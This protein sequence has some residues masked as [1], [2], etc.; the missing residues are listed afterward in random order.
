MWRW[1]KWSGGRYQARKRQCEG[2]SVSPVDGSLFIKWDSRTEMDFFYSALLPSRLT[3]YKT[4][5][6][7]PSIART[8]TY[9]VNMWICQ[10]EPYMCQIHAT[11]VTEECEGGRCLFNFLTFSFYCESCA[12]HLVSG[13]KQ[14]LFKCV[15][16]FALLSKAVGKKT[17]V[18]FRSYC[19]QT[20]QKHSRGYIFSSSFQFT[21]PTARK[22]KK[23]TFSQQSDKYFRV[24]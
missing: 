16:L 17:S 11:W 5:Q 21:A 6:R 8:W 24:N 20:N 7:Q 23:K 22:K 15:H 12:V 10:S 1:M 18:T 13:C 4:G 3:N 9:C 19:V 14:C 2:Q